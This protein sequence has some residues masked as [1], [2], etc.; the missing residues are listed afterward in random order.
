MLMMALFKLRKPAGMS[1]KEFYTVWQKEAEAAL[2][3][4]RQGA[5]K[6]LWKVAGN[7]WVIGIIDVNVGDDIDHALQNLPIWKL[8]YQH[9]VES[10][11][12]FPLRPYENWAEDLKRLAAEAP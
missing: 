3:A 7:P 11:D 1:D 9:I 8:G 6:A 5:V 2:E 10:I 12:W 4:L